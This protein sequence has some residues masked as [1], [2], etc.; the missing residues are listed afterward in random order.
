MLGWSLLLVILPFASDIAGDMAGNM[1]I[2]AARVAFGEGGDLHRL[3]AWLNKKVA[4][5]RIISVNGFTTVEMLFRLPEVGER[6]E[7]L[8]PAAQ[9]LRLLPRAVHR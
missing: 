6:T 2:E 7:A 1:P 3:M 9:E 8:Q 4:D 5:H